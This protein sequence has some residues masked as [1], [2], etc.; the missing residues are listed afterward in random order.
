MPSTL[1]R[2]LAEHVRQVRQADWPALKI[3]D[4]WLD[5]LFLSVRLNDGSVG[6]A[7][8]YDQEGDGI[9]RSVASA[10]RNFLIEQ[11]P[12]Q[13]L[14]WDLLLAPAPEGEHAQT[15]LLIATLS[16]LSAPVLLD[17]GRL[18]PLGLKS[19]DGRIPLKTF[20]GKKRVTIIGAGGYLVEALHQDWLEQVACCD[21]NFADDSFK[22]QNPFVFELVGEARK[23]MNVVT[24]AGANTMRL[25]EGGHR[26]HHGLHAVQLHLG[27]SA[28]AHPAR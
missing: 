8:N 17:E 13:P 23:R 20:Q 22:S 27:G 26:V 14:L 2:D 10:T 16:A 18:Q 28:A 7:L 1:Y 25:I 24:D 11:I 6:V 21:F 15:A 19:S 4:L 12:Q 9:P 5:N 3:D